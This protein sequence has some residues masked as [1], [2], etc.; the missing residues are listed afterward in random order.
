M[1]LLKMLYKLQWFFEFVH[2]IAVAKRLYQTVNEILLISIPLA[3][4]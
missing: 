3:Y 4:T 1:H 2:E